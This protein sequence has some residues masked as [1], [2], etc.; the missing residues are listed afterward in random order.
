MDLLAVCLSTEGSRE[1]RLK[2]LL[3]E[4]L[5][6]VPDAEALA[7][8]CNQWD[9]RE[10]KLSLVYH[11]V[12]PRS[13]SE[14]ERYEPLH[15]P[16]LRSALNTFNDRLDDAIHAHADRPFSS[17]ACDFVEDCGHDPE[18]WRRRF[19]D[20]MGV[21]EVRVFSRINSDNR[22]VSLS[23]PLLTGAPDLNESSQLLLRMV[24]KLIDATVGGEGL[25]ELK[26]N[27]R[28]GL[29]KA[30]QPVFNLAIEGLTEKQIALRLHRSPHTIHS[31]LRSI[32][33]N[34][35]VN[36]RAELLALHLDSNLGK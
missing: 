18:E 13:S 24:A 28:F 21:G 19:F 17:L 35:K 15:A 1:T 31:H 10:R 25:A 36:S 20:P 11:K 3:V 9:T 4:T 12:A 32:Y 2:K 33:R 26:S 30:Q 14:A 6:R 23:A 5:L 16:E 27:R 29:S 34:F 22:M 8:S 7:I